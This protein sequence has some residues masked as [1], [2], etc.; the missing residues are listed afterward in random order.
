MNKLL[1]T[2]KRIIIKPEI[3]FGQP[4]IMGTRITIAD[5]LHLIETGY[6]INDIPTQYPT[7]NLNMARNAVRYASN[8]LGKEEILSIEQ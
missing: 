8:I 5:V 1:N 2:T 3:R 7:V 6:H 4:T